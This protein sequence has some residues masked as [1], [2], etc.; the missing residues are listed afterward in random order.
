M[1]TSKMT[2]NILGD[3]RK[4][5]EELYSKDLIRDYKKESCKEIA[6]DFYEISFSG[7]DNSICNVVYDKHISGEEIIDTLL[8]GYQYNVLLYD[9]SIIQAE[10]KIEKNSVVKERLVFFKET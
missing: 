10:F 3:M 5:V 8:A 7:K 1:S 2:K 4:T 6:K 9:K